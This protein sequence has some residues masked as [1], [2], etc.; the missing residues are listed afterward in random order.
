MLSK[1]AN[2][3]KEILHNLDF[4]GYKQASENIE[5]QYMFNLEEESRNEIE[6]LGGVYNAY[7]TVQYEKN[8]NKRRP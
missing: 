5:M 6:L 1:G 2:S 7:K 3:F 8:K 4:E